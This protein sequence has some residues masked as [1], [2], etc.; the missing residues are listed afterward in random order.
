M[1]TVITFG[2][3]DLFHIGHLNILRRASQLGDRLVVG[4][5]SDEFTYRKKTRDAV[6]NQK[7]RQEIVKSLKWVTDTF[8]EESFE[9]KLQYILDQKA[10]IF[11]MG[12]D[13]KGMFDEFKTV[14]EVVYLPRTTGIS[15][16]EILEAI[17][18]LSLNTQ[19]PEHGDISEQVDNVQE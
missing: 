9:H 15:T 7:D 6:F 5:S 10:D 2:T 12:D 19:L 3:F 4:I 16:T 18:D 17:Q 13:W 1:K 8:I 11:V 14:C